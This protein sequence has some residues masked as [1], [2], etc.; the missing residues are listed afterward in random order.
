MR[1]CLI[2]MKDE[3]KLIFRKEKKEKNHK[4]IFLLI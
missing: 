2:A 4:T 3:E 1:T